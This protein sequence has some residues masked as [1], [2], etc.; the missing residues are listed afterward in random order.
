MSRTLVRIYTSEKW[1]TSLTAIFFNSKIANPSIRDRATEY[2]AR[3]KAFYDDIQSL[4][5][6]GNCW[7]CSSRNAKFYITRTE[8][9]LAGSN[10]A[11]NFFPLWDKGV[12]ICGNCIWFVQ[13][14]PLVFYQCVNFA[15]L[16]SNSQKIMQAWTRISLKDVIAQLSIGDFTG[17]NNLGY[18]NPVN[19][20]FHIVMQI[21]NLSTDELQNE[22]PFIRLVLFSNYGQSPSLKFLDFPSRIFTFLRDV[23]ISG[24]FNDWQKFVF[25][26]TNRYLKDNS[27]TEEDLLKDRKNP[28]YERLIAMKS[29]HGYFINKKK[30]SINVPWDV[31]RL[32][33]EEVLK[34]NPER[35]QYIKELG[36]KIV[37]IMKQTN[38]KKRL[39][40]LERAKSYDELRMALLF[41]AKDSMKIK[42]AP[43]F[44][45]EELS[46]N[47]FPDTEYGVPWKESRDFLLFRIYESG[48]D[49]LKQF[50][51]EEL[52]Q[53]ELEE[54]EEI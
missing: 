16:Q 37:E 24:F 7:G 9:P 6:K 45:I 22:T 25:S 41:L 51:Q 4:G 21:I 27:R 12:A 8:L 13:F 33:L 5:N 10:K 23:K 40:A 30:R 17:I 53:E 46:K 54:E 36:D 44:Q 32:Y 20:L 3:L 15:L 11:I 43:I 29:I 42:D 38:N 49:F 1:Q 39:Y 35:I 2:L 28:I 14:A 19:F 26:R 48:F 34:I 50:I 31:F 18:K 52:E 47:L